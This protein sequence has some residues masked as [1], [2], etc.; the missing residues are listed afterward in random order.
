MYER[1]ISEEEADKGRLFIFKNKLADFPAVGSSIQ[2]EADGQTFEAKIE[3]DPCTCVGPDKPHHHYYL[4]SKELAETVSKK[5]G[6][7]VTVYK[8]GDK[9]Y[10][11]SFT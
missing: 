7:V 11:L 1:R 10:R 9:T 3:A 6:E 5:K 8:I 2:V 4:A